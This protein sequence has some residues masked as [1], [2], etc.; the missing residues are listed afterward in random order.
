MNERADGS[1]EEGR[2]RPEEE[3]KWDQRTDRMTFE[4]KAGKATK[5]SVWTDSVRNAFRKQAGQAKLLDAYDKAAKHWTER[6]WYCKNQRWMRATKA[7]ERAARAGK[8]KEEETWGKEC[9]KKLEQEDLGKPATDT[10]WRRRLD[11][12]ALD[13]EGKKC[14]PIEFKRKRDQRLSY[15]EEATKVAERQYES[16]LTGLQAV[17]EQR[18]WEIKQIV[19]VGGTCG[20][21]GEDVFNQN[22]KLL[23]VVESRWSTIRQRLARRL[24]E[25][26]DKVLRSYFAQIYGGE[27]QGGG[28]QGPGGKGPGR[29]HLGLNVYA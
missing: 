20:S 15:E 24:L 2:V 17:G 4:V 11:G 8:F 29:E 23:E 6:V 13:K 9:F 18:G 10:F 25:E 21:V 19:F 27:S 22:M 26:H 14:Y 7:G 5:V 28:G 12:I 16:L 1:A 3:K